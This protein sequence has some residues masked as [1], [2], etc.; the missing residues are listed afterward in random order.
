MK[1]RDQDRCSMA[2][3][4]L[5]MAEEPPRIAKEWFNRG[6][7]EED[8]VFA[9]ICYWITFNQLYSYCAQDRMSERELIKDFIRNYRDI[10]KS[11]LDFS[12]PMMDVFFE[13]PVLEKS[14]SATGLDWFQ[15]KAGILDE[16]Y[17]M[18]GFYYD[19]GE[20]RHIMN[21][22]LDLLNDGNNKLSRIQILFMY[23]YQ[24]RCNLFHGNKTPTPE[25]DWRLV[26]SSAQILEIVLPKLIVEVFGC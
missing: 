8:T 7:N 3:T 17:D 5:Y 23:I 15:S 16:L 26:E 1:D 6:K 10:F 9:F 25:R 21:M 12:D 4:Y 19:K 14:A 22:H 18:I 24:V 11:C 13:A 2:R 20:C